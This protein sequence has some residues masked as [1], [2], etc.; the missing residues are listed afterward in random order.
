M[1]W[2]DSSRPR[3]NRSDH[4]RTPDV[5]GLETQRLVEGVEPSPAVNQ[6]HIMSTRVG[7]APDE[8]GASNRPVPCSHLVAL[9]MK[10]R[11]EEQKLGMFDSEAGS[12]LGD[13]SPCEESATVRHDPKPRHPIP[14][15]A[16]R[17]QGGRCR[18][19][20]VLQ[21]RDLDAGTF[22]LWMQWDLGSPGSWEAGRFWSRMTSLILR[23][24]GPLGLQPLEAGGWLW[25]SGG[26]VHG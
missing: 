16:I 18:M 3:A 2:M 10:L 19:G 17:I 23:T 7:L 12:S 9:L 21:K 11:P 24:P 26:M 13:A 25:G 14:L 22:W 1:A 20:A 6:G 15:N 5:H 4:L 8:A